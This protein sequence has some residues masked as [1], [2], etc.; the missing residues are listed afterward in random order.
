MDRA[1]KPQEVIVCEQLTEGELT[2]SRQADSQINFN[3]F[4]PGKR[5][6]VNYEEIEDDLAM[7]GIAKFTVARNN[8]DTEEAYGLNVP[9]PNLP[10]D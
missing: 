8:G 3:M 10:V 9:D 5:Y 4:N 7:P 1:T 6:L 2:F